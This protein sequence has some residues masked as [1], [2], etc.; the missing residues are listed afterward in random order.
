M[1]GVDIPIADAIDPVTPDDDRAS[2][3][4]LIATHREKN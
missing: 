1:K 4:E 3:K 2:A